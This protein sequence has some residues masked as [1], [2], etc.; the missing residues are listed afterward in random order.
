MKRAGTISA[1]IAHYLRHGD[2]DA[3]C[4]AWP[5][6]FLDRH[7]LAHHDLR[8]ALAAEVTRRSAGIA[9]ALLQNVPQ[10]GQVELTHRRIE[11]MVRG[12]FAPDEQ[13][14][15][16]DRLRSSVV[17][18]T[19][20]NI[21]EL[22]HGLTWHHTAWTVANM[23][24]RS[25]GLEPMGGRDGGRDSAPVG[26]SEE[27]TCYL[28]PEYFTE[29][30]PYADFV[31]HEVAHIFHNCKR[32]TL[33]LKQTRTREWLLDIE[34]SER[35]TFAYSCEAYSRVING[36][37]DRR[38]RQR[39]AEAFAES[40][41]LPAHAVDEQTVIDIVRAAAASRSGR[42]HILARCAPARPR[43]TS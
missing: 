18:I 21:D 5:G 3:E 35:E 37:A 19:G 42:R 33:G 20:G 16:L 14:T 17:F 34:F 38:E 26:M 4:S 32:G 15:V 43:K 8:Q 41:R 29:T 9:P 39:R 28:T 25:L 6:G 22:I 36:S 12:L 30:D 27:I 31:V 10:D 13:D 23:H 24:L 2:V 40:A 11:P 1:A 7:R